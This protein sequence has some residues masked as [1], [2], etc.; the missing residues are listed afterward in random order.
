MMASLRLGEF[1]K[2]LFPARKQVI[3]KADCDNLVKSSEHSNVGQALHA[4]P[5]W[6]LAELQLQAVQALQQLPAGITLQLASL[7]A[8][9]SDILLQWRLSKSDIELQV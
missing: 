2:V 6:V 1:S 4:G 7:L 8:T 5:S 3:A 9:D